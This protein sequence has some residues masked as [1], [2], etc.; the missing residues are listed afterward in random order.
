MFLATETP[1]APRPGT[2]RRQTEKINMHS[3][4]TYSMGELVWFNHAAFFHI[5]SLQAGVPEAF[6][7]NF[8]EENLPYNTYYGDGTRIDDA[9]ANEVL[10]AYDAEKI[11]FPWRD[12]D[13]LLLDNMTM[14]H[15]RQPYKGTRQVI[16]AMVEPYSDATHIR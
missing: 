15:G 11:I 6:M 5:S 1:A 3:E 16:V 10:A 9:E 14:A 2:A 13:V 8:S 7:N 12:G 4:G